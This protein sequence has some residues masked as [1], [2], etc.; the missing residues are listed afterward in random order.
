M[1]ERAQSK[2]AFDNCQVR[3]VVEMPDWHTGGRMVCA[4]YPTGFEVSMWDMQ[5]EDKRSTFAITLGCLACPYKKTEL[6]TGE[7]AVEAIKRLS[8][9]A[10]IDQLNRL[11]QEQDARD[12]H[13]PPT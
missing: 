13:P 7:S 12:S 3:A 5:L 9:Q 2:K 1:R 4:K 11:I 8:S 6:Q 10:S